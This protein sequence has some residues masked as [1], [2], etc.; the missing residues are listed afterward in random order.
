MADR[1]VVIGVGADGRL[2]RP[3][4]EGVRRVA[5]GRRHLDVHAPSGPATTVLAG[6][7]DGALAEIEGT[8]GTVAVLAS[9]DPGWFGIVRRLAAA[10]G[11]E[12][13]E[14]HPAASSVAAA[15]ARVGLAWEDAV[16][17]SAHGREPGAAIA[18]A[19]A[20]PKVAVL[21]SPELTPAALASRLAAAGCGPRRVVVA[22]RLGHDDAAVHETDLTRAA[23]LEVAD[24]NV[25][26]LIDP[27]RPAGHPA[28]G[29]PSSHGPRR[30]ATVLGHL[31]A[32]RPWARPADVYRHR[33]G[34]VS[35]PEVRA[36]ALAHLAPG[37]GRLLWDLGCGSGSV[38]VEAAGLG[39]GVVALDRDAEQL[40]RTRA[41]AHHHD[42]GLGLVHGVCPDA[43]A[44]LPD[45]DAVF[46]GGG[47]GRLPAI[48]EAVTARARDRIAVA[49]AT[50][51]RAGPCL[52]QLRGAGWHADAQLVQIHDLAP[53]GS[54]HRLAPRNPVV[55][56]L[57]RRPL[58]THTGGSS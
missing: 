11:T 34:Q 22:A 18:A 16:V 20:H 53:L 46:V 56:V 44:P 57:A 26:L 40:A 43:L 28:S 55:L 30:P 27:D 51:E 1:I 15:F 49:L 48:L 52:E 13:L 5:G 10:V 8:A 54:G 9:G 6:D 45:P 38:A 25:V 14:V 12:R 2:A 32:P 58:A 33:D 23:D 24:P 37:P 39:A 29:R 3:L 31:P 42:V 36:L 35:K 17:V 19:L 21:T 4:P 50:V 7:L 41:N 47:G